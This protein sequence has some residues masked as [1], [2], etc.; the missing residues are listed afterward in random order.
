MRKLSARELA[1]R[2]RA[3]QRKS[4]RAW[5]A[6]PGNLKK[7]NAKCREAYRTRRREMVRLRGLQLPDDLR[8]V[9][10]E[11]LK[12]PRVTFIDSSGR[13][14][15]EDLRSASQVIRDW[16]RE[17]KKRGKAEGRDSD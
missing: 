13:V 4:F 14:R 2:Q 6:R 11:T 15:G 10:V 9:T 7:H 12:A 3:R 16:K 17:E 5:L 8:C 1:K